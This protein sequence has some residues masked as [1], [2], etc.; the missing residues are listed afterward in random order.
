MAISLKISGTSYT[1]PQASVRS[2][3]HTVQACQPAK[4]VAQIYAP[5]IPTTTIPAFA[6]IELWV[7]SVR[8]FAGTLTTAPRLGYDAQGSYIELTAAD[9]LA[10]LRS[11]TYERPILSWTGLTAP[12]PAE[13]GFPD[14]MQVPLFRLSGNWTSTVGLF[15]SGT[16]YMDTDAEGDLYAIRSSS[17]S[18]AELAR[19]VAFLSTRAGLTLE[20]GTLSGLPSKNTGDVVTDLDCLSVLQ[21][22]ANLRPDAVFWI[23]PSGGTNRLHYITRDNCTEVTLDCAQKNLITANE[24]VA[25]DD[26]QLGYLKWDLKWVIVRDD[27]TW[28]PSG[29]TSEFGDPAAAPDRRL[30][31][32]FNLGKFGLT[33]AVDGLPYAWE[34]PR[35]AA[36]AYWAAASVLHYEG[37]VSV[38]EP[39]GVSYDYGLGQV[40][41][42]AN[43]QPAYAT[44]R[45]LVR[46]VSYDLVSRR[47]SIDFGPPDSLTPQDYLSISASSLG[48]SSPTTD[49]TDPTTDPS[50]PSAPG[51]GDLPAQVTGGL[52]GQYSILSTTGE[53][54]V[55]E[56]TATLKGW[57]ALHPSFAEIPPRK[58]KSLS[59]SGSLYVEKD[60]EINGSI[61]TTYRLT[62]N[63]TATYDPITDAITPCVGE[64]TITGATPGGPVN[65]VSACSHGGLGNTDVQFAFFASSAVAGYKRGCRW[66]YGVTDQCPLID[67]EDPGESE[68]VFAVTKMYSSGRVNVA[69]LDEDTESDAIARIGD[70]W[71]DPV[72]TGEKKTFYEQRTT[73]FSF[74]VRR[75]RLHGYTWTA[76]IYGL[77]VEIS[78]PL[79]KYPYGGTKPA[80]PTAT[81]VWQLDLVQTPYTTTG[82]HGLTLTKYRG[83]ATLPDWELPIEQGY[84]IELG[85]LTVSLL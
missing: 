55:I 19:L 7:D 12:A 75:C 65:L 56:G 9:V 85:D 66:V 47:T 53:V 4:L 34:I 29:N 59:F 11:I 71:A 57:N 74:A 21:R 18:A 63:G 44:A 70:T 31:R 33:S 10:R 8:R 22:C 46:G 76:S 38:Y 61:D 49:P 84:V 3:V 73:G 23:D 50:D 17:S 36:A 51:S 27:G 78:A 60:Y 54:Q 1:L 25:R 58:W 77:P 16:T 24:C 35:D 30:I 48:S 32:S 41:N 69:L 13:W 40:L 79:Y 68:W 37:S 82:E 72:G 6:E 20:L 28:Y 80:T 43:W 26:L 42:F 64:W 39:D 5:A 14:G 52:A 62:A 67:A 83:V 15:S 45:A 81:Q 2:L